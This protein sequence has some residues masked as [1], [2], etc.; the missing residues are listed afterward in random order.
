MKKLSLFKRLSRKIDKKVWKMKPQMISG[1]I[2]IL[3]VPTP[4]LMRK[5]K[6]YKIKL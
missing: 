3:A 6:R 1:G 2:S 5:I 4:K